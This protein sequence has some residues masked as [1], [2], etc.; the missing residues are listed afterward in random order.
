[1]IAEDLRAGIVSGQRAPGARLPGENDLMRQYGVA[2]MTARQALAV[3]HAEGLTVARQG[4]GVYVR[5]SRPVRRRAGTPPPM[6]PPR[7][8]SGDGSWAAGTATVAAPPVR[9]PFPTGDPARTV[10]LDQ[11]EVHPE[12]ASPVVAGALGLPESTPV[13]ARSRRFLLD[14]KPVMLAVSYFPAALVDGTAITSEDRG[15]GGTYARL[16]ELGHP[17]VRF[18]EELRARMPLRHETADLRLPTGTPVIV[19]C[20]TGFAAD[21]RPVEFSRLTLD[22]DAYVLEYGVPV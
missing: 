2:R 21:G 6:V 1:V 16:A 5:D 13:W 17:P 7:P 3:L 9:S 4:S 10:S 12:A 19:L 8:R 22:A 11:V 15:P 18:T 20:R 14:G